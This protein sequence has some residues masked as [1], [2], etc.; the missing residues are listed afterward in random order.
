MRTGQLS[1]AQHERYTQPCVAETV[2]GHGWADRRTGWSQAKATAKGFK[3][4]DLQCV[5]SAQRGRGPSRHPAGCHGGC[6]Q[7]HRNAGRSSSR[8]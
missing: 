2:V 8:H 4:A 5:G 3:I 7:E 1:V 6:E